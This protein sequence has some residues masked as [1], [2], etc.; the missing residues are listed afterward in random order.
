MVKFTSQQLMRLLGAL[1]AAAMALVVTGDHS[2]ASY[3]VSPGDDRDELLR[4]CL[5]T[6]FGKEQLALG[7]AD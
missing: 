5:S 6:P 1:A 3:G 7:Q 4:G 2:G